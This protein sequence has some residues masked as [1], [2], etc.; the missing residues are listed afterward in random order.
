MEERA[1]HGRV[2]GYARSVS[3]GG[4]SLHV[5]RSGGSFPRI[6]RPWRQIRIASFVSCAFIA[7]TLPSRTAPPSHRSSAS[8]STGTFQRPSIRYVVGHGVVEKNTCKPDKHPNAHAVLDA[9][10]SAIA[11]A[12]IAKNA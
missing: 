6:Y 7:L 5:L 10:C 2:W 3:T 1:V 8:H 4:R 11:T 9:A 12:S